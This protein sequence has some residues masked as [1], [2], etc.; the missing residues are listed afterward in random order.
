VDSVEATAANSPGPRICPSAG[1]LITE[2]AARV[3]ELARTVHDLE[4]LVLPA[5]ASATDDGGYS[6]HSGYGDGYGD[7]DGDG[8][9]TAR[10]E[11]DARDAR[12][13]GRVSEFSLFTT[14]S[15]L[16]KR[17]AEV[18][19]HL[20]DGHSNRRI[21]RSLRISES[22]VKNHLH[23]IFVKLDTRDRTQVVA[24]VYRFMAQHS[25]QPAPAPEEPPG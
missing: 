13:V 16:T 8:N 3:A 1:A 23:A 7:S 10:G 19:C 21:S 15:H 4:R 18:L 5:S 12:G 9:G 14:E 11:P 6:G 24:K 17:E 20:L 25:S 22:T 2:V